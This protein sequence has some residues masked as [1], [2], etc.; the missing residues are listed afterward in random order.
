MVNIHVC[1]LHFTIGSQTPPNNTR[2]IMDTHIHHRLRPL[3][4]ALL[5][6]L[7]TALLT[8]EEYLLINGGLVVP[9]MPM[10]STSP[11]S[12]SSPATLEHAVGPSPSLMLAEA[13]L[14][15]LAALERSLG[16]GTAL[17]MVSVQPVALPGSA[18]ATGYAVARP[19][20]HSTY[21]VRLLDVT[22]TSADSGAVAASL[23]C[24]CGRMH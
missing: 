11:P 20:L 22:R 18:L 7:S 15:R 3:S 14:L 6:P 23:A 21:P 1:V 24:G 19:I 2:H 10:L 13:R 12:T 16:V 9:P 4:T 8:A 17:S 5:R